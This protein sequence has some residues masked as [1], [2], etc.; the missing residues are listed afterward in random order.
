[1]SRIVIA[2]IER[3]GTIEYVDEII[4][5]GS[6][7]DVYF[8]PDKKQALAFFRT[9]QDEPS[10]QRLRMITGS[11]RERIF[12][13]QGGE[14]WEQLFCWPTRLVERYD[15]RIGVLMPIYDQRFFFEHGSINADFLGI[16]G[17]EKQGKWFASP[18]NRNSFL[19]QRE[20]GNW[21]GY[22]RVS[23]LISRALRRLHA[24][25]LAH[26]DLSYKNILVDPVKG[27]ACLID[28]DGLVV[29]GKYPPDVIGTPDFIAPEVMQTAHLSRHD[30]G[31]SLPCINTDR[32]ALA[33]LIYMYLLLRHPLRGE[34]IQDAEDPQRD[35]SLAMGECALFIEHPKDPSNRLDPAD[36][37][38]S[39][40][41]WKDTEALPYSITGPYL[42]AL[43]DRAL[44]EGLHEPQLRPSADEW[45]QALVKTVD[46]I[47]PCQNPNCLQKWYVFDNTRAP[48]CPFCG[49]AYQGILPAINFHSSKQGEAFRPDNHRLM[50][51][52]GQ[53]LFPWHIDRSVMPNERLNAAQRKRVGYFLFH[54]GNWLLVNESMP[55]LT[56]LKTNQPIAI[57]QAVTLEEGSRLLL[58]RQNG[59]R[60]AVLQLVRGG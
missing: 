55:E 44:I 7:K 47:Q 27:L 42:S 41:P 38:P 20:R 5:S 17:K 60:L 15:G 53:S 32:H 9:P 46:L 45:E 23:I 35:E 43:F 58:S 59:G 8:T 10:R 21:L 26:S 30:A 28:L 40:L 1:M 37:R 51:Y 29:P 56:D 6:M 31:K 50:V 54:N 18:N 48:R 13:Q 52:T 49:T 12:Q 3:G 11:F 33:V 19:D 36:A 34:K 4:A 2:K 25:G 14:Y 22:L 57:G 16:R 39:E 24:A